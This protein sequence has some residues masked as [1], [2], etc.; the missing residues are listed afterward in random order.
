MKLKKLLSC[1]LSA[2][3]L[4]MSCTAAE[5][6]AQNRQDV[7]SDEEIIEYNDNIGLLRAIG[8]I[9]K[10]AEYDMNDTLTRGEMIKTIMKLFAIPP[11][12]ISSAESPYSDVSKDTPEYG[13]IMAATEKGIVNGDS[14]TFRPNDK[15]LYEEASKMVVSMLG[16]RMFAEKAGGYPQ[17]YLSEAKRLGIISSSIGY[18]GY[19][20]NRFGFAKMLAESLKTDMMY[21]TMDGSGKASYEIAF[22]KNILKDIFKIDTIDGVV[23]RSIYTA[24]NEPQAVY[25]EIVAIDGTVYKTDCDTR[26]LIGC[27]V[28]AYANSDDEIV[29]I[30]S[31]DKYNNIMV[32]D[33]PN[34]KYKDFA[35]EYEVNNRTKRVKI[36]SKFNFI[37]N[38]KAKI[39]FDETQMVPDDG[40]IELIDADDDNIYETVK[41]YNYR[42]MVV[43][44]VDA[45]NETVYAKYGGD[46]LELKNA[47]I[48][49]IKDGSGKDKAYTELAEYNVLKFLASDDNE[50]ILAD[51]STKKIKGSINTFW[52]DDDTSIVTVNDTSYKTISN[53]IGDELDAGKSG[54]IY[55]SNDDKI[56][57]F[58]SGNPDGTGI[59]ILI[60]A[61][62][63]DDYDDYL[64]LKIFTENGEIVKLNSAKRVSVDGVTK[65]TPAALKDALCKGM[66][67]IP[68]QPIFYTMNDEGRVI[69]IDTAYNIGAAYPEDDPLSVSSPSGEKDSSIRR[70]FKGSANYLSSQSTFDGK[71]NLSDSTKIF[72]V[73]ENY[74]TASKEDFRVGGKASLD[75]NISYTFDAFSTTETNLIAD[76]I[77]TN[78]SVGASGI[79][80][81][82][83]DV[84]E[85]YDKEAAE[86]RTKLLLSSWN[87]DYEVYIDQ[88]DKIRNAHSINSE[89]TNTYDI[90]VGD[91]VV[92]S[93]AGNNKIDTIK[94]IVDASEAAE[95]RFKGA[96]NPTSS[97]FSAL[98]RMLY[99]PVDTNYQSIF[100]IKKG[101]TTEN[102]NTKGFKIYKYE[103][104]RKKGKV[105]QI[106]SS[107]VY[108]MKN[109]GSDANYVL[110]YSNWAEPRI[111]VVY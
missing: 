53:V 38:N 23:T 49:E 9:D 78:S 74:A 77:I 96:D 94:L 107:D 39:N 84:I 105:T 87:K 2:S 51:V 26:E 95:N 40:Y 109:F 57:A 37:L 110:M 64:I 12:D 102:C 111:M 19:P 25:G 21:A 80:G 44:R 1:I 43:N 33:A 104:L 15:A 90:S 65:K 79:Y 24:L 13:Y 72:S 99:G 98:H 16:Y 81:V 106:N 27:K 7:Y 5:I 3:L 88:P 68:A 108:D 45:S 18:N 14:N 101:D 30:E 92:L 32:L 67:T 71:L 34:V 91:F 63:P 73:P 10:N 41:V 52:H 47:D 85:E 62:E 66:D 58:I 56:V 70:V 103:E 61:I 75:N 20:I 8:I 48:L 22:D 31:R 46:K 29:Y 60:A 69:I 54:V 76:I 59:G 55:L 11:S 4:T 100:A 93:I 42:Y 86:V 83:R 50:I 82:V 89:D 17:G 36:P 35:Y 6:F 97:S 28:R